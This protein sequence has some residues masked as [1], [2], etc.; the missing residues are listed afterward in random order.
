MTSLQLKFKSDN[1]DFL[2]DFKINGIDCQ[3]QIVDDIIN[4]RWDFNFGFY[5]LEISV[6]S[7]VDSTK[8]EI[9]DAILDGVSFRQT[10]CLAFGKDTLGKRYQTRVLDQHT[11]KIHI[12]FINPISQWISS[13]AEK[14][15]RYEIFD[16]TLYDNYQIYYPESVDVPEKFPKIIRD[17]FKHDFSFHA[18]P[19]LIEEYY[20][21]RVPY[22]PI[23][24][25]HLYD[26][27]LL[28]K[29][30]LDQF[31]YIKGIS[32]EPG[33]NI[34]NSV[35]ASRKIHWSVIDVIVSHPVRYNLESDFK[36]DKDRVPQLYQ[37]I[38]NLNLDT[39]VHV[40]IGILAPGEFISPHVD[41]YHDYQ[42]ILKDFGGCSQ[43]YIPIN[44]K[45]GN[46]FKLANVG[47]LPL[48]KPTLINNHN[49]SHA[50]INDSSEYR[51]SIAVVGSN[52]L[53]KDNESNINTI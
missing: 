3:Y 7:P 48:D 5:L 47:L 25:E 49:F 37:L 23:N 16:H 42:Y 51:F 36:L 24:I 39:I 4:I 13:C 32:R 30:L 18:H 12:P 22:A 41:S 52:L 14:I 43:I 35:D 15:P 40:F 1:T 26:E 46:L 6:I 20:D 9:I 34:Y 38:K 10:L 2:L 28:A 53:Q 17:F 33:Q 29:E 27:R 21:P 31:E 44:F 19:R 50:L 11:Q 8:I 45:P